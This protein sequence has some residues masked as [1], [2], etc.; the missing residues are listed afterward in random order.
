MDIEELHTTACVNQ[1]LMFKH[2]VTGLY[3]MTKYG[4][5]KNGKCC[6]RQCLYCPYHHENVQGHVCTTKTCPNQCYMK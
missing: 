2:P 1:K 6:G 3:V 5:L 4:L